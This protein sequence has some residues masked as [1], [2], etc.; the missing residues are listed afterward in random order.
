MRRFFFL[1]VLFLSAKAW[2]QSPSLLQTEILSYGELWQQGACAPCYDLNVKV[3]AGSIKEGQRIDAVSDYGTRY[4]FVVKTISADGRQA[5]LLG[6]GRRGKVILVPQGAT[7]GFLS[8][9]DE[10][11]QLVGVGGVPKAALSASSV[12]KDEKP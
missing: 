6:M 7:S 12:S 11:F 4:T 10:R 9:T 8:Q 5:P 1:L 2:S 3:L